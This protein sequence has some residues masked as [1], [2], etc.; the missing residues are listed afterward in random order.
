ML[1]NLKTEKN[2]SAQ[3]QQQLAQAVR[4]G[5]ADAI[6]G[7]APTRLAV[8]ARLVRNNLHGFINHCYTE[9][10]NYLTAEQW[11]DL[12]ENFVQNGC[13]QSPYFQDIAAEFLK[14]CREQR[15]LP[16]HLL[17]LMDLEQT[18]LAAEVAQLPDYPHEFEWDEHT[19]FKRA[20]TAFL[21]QYPDEFAQ[22]FPKDALTPAG[23][24]L[25]WRNLADEVYTRAIN[26]TDFILLNILENEHACLQQIIVQLTPL[27]PQDSPWQ[28]AIKR[29]WQHWIEQDVLIPTTESS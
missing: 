28:S 26:P 22:Y 17:A 21:C 27:M 10:P 14:H 24:I 8:Y 20:P 11:H 4:Q 3:F 7:F 12:K 29:H 2:P 5:N 16:E 6:D 13:A 19:Q 23:M 15:A 18:Q 25:V 1:L 9:T